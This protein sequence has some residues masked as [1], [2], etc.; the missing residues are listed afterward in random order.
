MTPTQMLNSIRS[1]PCQQ[2]GGS[3]T[4]E[5]VNGRPGHSRTRVACAY[6]DWQ[7]VIE[8]CE[9]TGESAAIDLDD[10][11]CRVVDGS[12]RSSIRDNRPAKNPAEALTIQERNRWYSCGRPA[13]ATWIA[14]G[15]LPAAKWRQ[16]KARLAEE[17]AE[18][19][20]ATV[21]QPNPDSV[22]PRHRDG[23]VG[24]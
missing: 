9:C 11:P 3:C 4:R 6:C 1:V 5:P 24:D 10:D 22:H 21:F 8:T 18:R 23:G 13:L 19:E 15:K 14:A 17:H 20:A 16:H 2:C 7:I 12:N